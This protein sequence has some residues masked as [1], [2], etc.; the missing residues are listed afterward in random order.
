MTGTFI[1]NSNIDELV[2]LA[3]TTPNKMKRVGINVSNTMAFNT[4]RQILKELKT[5]MTIR[6]GRF[7]ERSVIVKKASFSNPVAQ[8]G[9]IRRE[10]FTGW[11]EQETGKKDAR[12]RTQTVA[13]RRGKF[14]N[15]VAPRFRMKPGRKKSLRPSDVGLNNTSSD[16]PAFLNIL[17]RKKNFRESFYI[18][19]R[20]KKLQ[21]GIYI[22]KGRTTKISFIVEGRI[23]TYNRRK[24]LRVQNLNPKDTQPEINRWMTRSISVIRQ[25][26]VQVEFNKEAKRMFKF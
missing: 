12:K 7:V 1:W 5:S 16:I 8:V 13:A 10:R 2:K 25:Q 6:S 26:D 15:R 18:P 4:R 23:R 21:R 14:R 19:A 20:Y 24:I 11:E 9:S 17:S 22:F 3:K